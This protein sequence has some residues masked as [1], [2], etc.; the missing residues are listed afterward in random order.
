MPPFDAHRN[1]VNPKTTETKFDHMNFAQDAPV[2]VDGKWRPVRIWPKDETPRTLTD[3]YCVNCEFGPNITLIRCQT[4][5]VRHKID[6][7]PIEVVIDGKPIIQER[8]ADIVT[9]RWDHKTR[10]SVDFAEPQV[11]VIEEVS[12]GI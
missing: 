12:D 8:K 5:I 3:C 10:E 2:L 1:Q 4:A 6:I 11:N 9:G 7:E